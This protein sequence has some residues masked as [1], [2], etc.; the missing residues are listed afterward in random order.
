MFDLGPDN[1]IIILSL[2]RFDAKTT[3]VVGSFKLGFQSRDS[4]ISALQCRGTGTE[5]D[6]EVVCSIEWVY[7]PSSKGG[8]VPKESSSQLNALLPVV[9]VNL[10][11]Y[12]FD[13]FKN[14]PDIC[15]STIRIKIS[16]LLGTQILNWW[17]TVTVDIPMRCGC[18]AMEGSILD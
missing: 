17:R 16:I 13:I 15:D 14:S 2:S 5:L 7:E 11:N 1:E 18:R 12:C 9:A 6:N 8:V 4:D 3:T 10:R